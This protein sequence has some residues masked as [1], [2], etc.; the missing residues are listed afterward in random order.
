MGYVY[1]GNER[2]NTPEIREKIQKLAEMLK[3]HRANEDKIRAFVEEDWDLGHLDID[4]L[5]NYYSGC[6]VED[7]HARWLASNHDC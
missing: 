4:T 2:Y 5:L 6:D 1:S 7:M 3:E